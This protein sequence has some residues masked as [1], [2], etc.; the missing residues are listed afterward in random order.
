M[1]SFGQS[2]R[3]MMNDI[4]NIVLATTGPTIDIEASET[5]RTLRV[6]VTAL[7]SLLAEEKLML[8]KRQEIIE[9]KDKEITSTMIKERRDQ[10]TAWRLHQKIIGLKEQKAEVQERLDLRMGE[11]D[12][13]RDKINELNNKVCLLQSARACSY[14]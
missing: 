2:S 5:V 8:A 1:S 9:S 11:T 3:T 6:K 12:L 7:E 14:A 4:K 10:W 13:L